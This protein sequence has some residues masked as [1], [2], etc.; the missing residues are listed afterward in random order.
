[1]IQKETISK[2]YHV[3]NH[4]TILDAEKCMTLSRAHL[5]GEISLKYTNVLITLST[6][7]VNEHHFTVFS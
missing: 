2:L 7:N 4:V 5:M 1:M 3:Y 6:N